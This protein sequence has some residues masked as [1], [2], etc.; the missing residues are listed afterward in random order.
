MWPTLGDEDDCSTIY[1]PA[2]TAEELGL[3]HPVD[4]VETGRGTQGALAP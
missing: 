3:F 1:L 2:K 4:P